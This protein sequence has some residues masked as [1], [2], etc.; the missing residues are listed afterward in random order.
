LV[1]AV[2][3]AQLVIEPC[4]VDRQFGGSLEVLSLLEAMHV[5]VSADLS[6]CIGARGAP[7]G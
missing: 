7:Y 5:G 6:N 3:H 4:G 2:L 1:S